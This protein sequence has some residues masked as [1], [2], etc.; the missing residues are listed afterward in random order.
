MVRYHLAP[1]LLSRRDP[2]TGQ[3]RKREFGSWVLVA[4]KLLAR[5]KGPAWRTPDRDA[6]VGNLGIPARLASDTPQARFACPHLQLLRKL[7]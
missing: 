1:P 6:G 7:R 4:F 3:L 5:L 2:V